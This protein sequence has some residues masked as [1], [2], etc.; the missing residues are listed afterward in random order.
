MEQLTSPRPSYTTFRLALGCL[1]EITEARQRLPTA[2]RIRPSDAEKGI[3]A[4]RV[5]FFANFV[6][7][8]GKSVESA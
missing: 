4:E 2:K 5:N 8:R 7:F 6:F 1:T 3:D